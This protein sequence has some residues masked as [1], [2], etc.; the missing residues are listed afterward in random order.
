MIKQLVVL[1]FAA[2]AMFGAEPQKLLV[3]SLFADSSIAA[4]VIRYT[5]DRAD[6]TSYALGLSG[7][8]VDGEWIRP[9]STSRALRLTVDATPLNAHNSDRIYVDGRRA[10]ELEYDNASYRARGGLRWTHSAR[11]STDV[12]LVALYESVDLARWDNPYGGVEI[13]HTYSVKNASEP[14]ISSFD[15]I[16]VTGRAELFAGDESWSRLS[17]IESA[18]RTFGRVHLRQSLAVLQGSSLDTVNRFLAGG[19]WDALGGT[20]IYGL[21]YGELRLESAVIASGGVDVRIGGNWRAGVRGSY[22]D[23]DTESTYG[24]AVN[25]ATTWKTIGVN[26]GVGVPEKRDGEGDPILYAALIVPLYRK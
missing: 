1:V 25:I 11:S 4:P 10:P 7:W 24:H 18:G 21:R 14:L 9:L 12:L 20:A 6:G 26:L 5:V 2:S 15:G 23:G 17:L 19:S 22:V 3:A 16:E 13:A 8:T